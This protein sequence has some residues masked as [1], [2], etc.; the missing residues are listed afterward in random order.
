MNYSSPEIILM[1]NHITLYVEAVKFSMN[2]YDKI[3]VHN[4][5]SKLFNEAKINTI[6]YHI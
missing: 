2:Y 4:F 3:M 1:I 5:L 6:N